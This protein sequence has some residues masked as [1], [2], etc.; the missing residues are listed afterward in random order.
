MVNIKTDSRKVKK[1]DIF[2]A[3]RGIVGDGHDFIPQAIKNGA[4][5]IIAEEGEYKVPYEIVKDSREYLNDYLKDN[6]NKYL[7]EMHII[8][9]T[10]TNGK[11]TTAYL[12]H[13]ALNKLDMKCCYIGTIG[14]FRD[15]KISDLSN[16]TPEV[17]EI[18]EMLI[19]AYDLGYRY[20]V[21][22]ASSEG[23]L[24]RRLEN[25]PFEYAIFTNLT[26][27]HLNIHGTME[28]YARCK[29]KLFNQIKPGGKA[30]VNYDDPNKDLFMLD[31][32]TNI[33]YGFKGGDYRISDYQ[34]SIMGS[35][36][37]FIN[38]GV[39]Q[40][41][42]VPLI[43]KYN[44]YN[45][46]TTIISL[47]ELGVNFSDIYDVL[48][49][50]VQTKIDE[51]NEEYNGEMDKVLMRFIEYSIIHRKVWAN[52]F[53]ARGREWLEKYVKTRIHYLALLQI[54]KMSEGYILSIKDVEII[55][56]FYEEAIFGLLIRWIIKEEKTKTVDEIK[57]TVERIEKLF[58]GQLDL[59]ISNMKK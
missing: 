52:L 45:V 21:V 30:I 5:K 31:Y 50:V 22:E 9:I 59:I 41:I 6:Y 17:S 40:N 42:K 46:L 28:N 33:T 10:G 56:S 34:M 49:G 16:T 12:V 53:D 32:N 36:F 43:G 57:D 2:V 8:G 11:T 13:D 58:E 7:N 4:S 19:E 54:R 44:I 25:V 1:G 26:Q 48:D 23:L 47:H 38:D 37:T 55:C 51:F 15:K 18:Y 27:D 20:A 3:L 14:Y 35:N 39:K 24:H 29:Q